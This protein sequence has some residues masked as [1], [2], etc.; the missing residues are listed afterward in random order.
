MPESLVSVVRPTLVAVFVSVTL[1]FGTI[2]WAESK[3]VP[4]TVL[5]LA[6]GSAVAGNKRAIA[7]A[8]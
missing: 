2:A 3:T 8:K 6:C 4:R 1:A 5:L 7:R